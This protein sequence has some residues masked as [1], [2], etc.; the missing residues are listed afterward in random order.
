MKYLKIQDAFGVRE[1]IF[2]FEL[3]FRP[4]L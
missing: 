3:R 4:V 1:A 2:D